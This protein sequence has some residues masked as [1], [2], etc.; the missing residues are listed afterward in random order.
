[1]R[2]TLLVIG[3]AGVVATPSL[4]EAHCH[5][6]KV[7]GAVIGGITGGSLGAAFATAPWGLA[8][9]GMGALVGGGLAALTCHH[10]YYEHA[11]YYGYQPGYYAYYPYHPRYYH[12]HYYHN[13][14]THH[15]YPKYYRG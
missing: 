1:M 13:Y 11:Y 8:A 9:A 6:A 4:A 5:H 3:L 14:Y 10:D 15:Y 7:A 12:H 2:K